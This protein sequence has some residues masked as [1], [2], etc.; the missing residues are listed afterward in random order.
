M[1]RDR[2]QTSREEFKTLHE[3]SEYVRRLINRKLQTWEGMT[4]M[5]DLLPNHPATAI[6]AIE[7]Y[8]LAHY[9]QLPDGRHHGLS[10]A[11]AVIRA[12]YIEAVTEDNLADTVGP[13]DYEF[14]VAALYLM[15]DYKVQVTRQTRERRNPKRLPNAS[16]S[17]FVTKP[18]IWS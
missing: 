2:L 8:H 12:K 9:D 3:T 13:R 5:I 7:A 17:D 1:W 11:V 16:A 6:A 15:S 4:W 10:D 18:P 14:L